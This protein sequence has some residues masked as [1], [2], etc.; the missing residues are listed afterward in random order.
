MLCVAGKICI[1]DPES[2]KV[3]LQS[4]KILQPRPW[5]TSVFLSHVHLSFWNSGPAACETAIRLPS[6]V[7]QTNPQRLH[8]MREK[9]WRGIVRDGALTHLSTHAQ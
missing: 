7:A 5:Q 2:S 1:V 9:L 8:R 4:H 6:V 3:H